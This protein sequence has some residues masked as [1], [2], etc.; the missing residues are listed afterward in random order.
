MI[1]QFSYA[2]LRLIKEALAM[3]A[4]RKESMGRARPRSARKHDAKA[5][6]MRRLHR[7]VCAIRTPAPALIADTS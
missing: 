2:E 3:A 1:P 4:S 6:E 5:E 7:K